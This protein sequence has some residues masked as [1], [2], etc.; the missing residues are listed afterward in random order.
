MKNYVYKVL[1]EDL[2]QLGAMWARP[3][4]NWEELAKDLRTAKGLAEDDYGEKIKW[5]KQN[6]HYTSGDL[7]YVMYTITKVKVY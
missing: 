1:S 7:R 6:G 4:F 3:G 5:E 2:T